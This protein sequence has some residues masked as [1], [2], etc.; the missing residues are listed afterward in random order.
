MVLSPYCCQSS[1]KPASSLISKAGILGS[2]R[3]RAVAGWPW[4]GPAGSREAPHRADRRRRLGALGAFEDSEGC[5]AAASPWPGSLPRRR[6]SASLPRVYSKHG[7][8]MCGRAPLRGSA[9]SPAAPLLV[10]S[11]G[12]AAGCT[13]GC[14]DRLEVPLLPVLASEQRGPAWIPWALRDPGC[15][16][17]ASLR[18][19]KPS[20]VLSASQG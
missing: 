9:L 14:R 17:A 3:G 10:C 19:Q 15:F 1:S 2:G 11:L 8:G 4:A 16:Q 20:P 6:D 7:G 18:P 13:V 12:C 5:V